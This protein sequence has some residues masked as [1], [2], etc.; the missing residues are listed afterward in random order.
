[1][2]VQGGPPVTL[3]PGQT[4]YE[5]S[6]KVDLLHVIRLKPLAVSP[7]PNQNGPS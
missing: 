2:Q 4:F 1:M 3:T 5:R 7:P 6:V